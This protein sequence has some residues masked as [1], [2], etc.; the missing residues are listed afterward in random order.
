MK[1]TQAITKILA[2]KYHKSTLSQIKITMAKT[3]EVP[4]QLTAMFET[5][6]NTTKN[7][8]IK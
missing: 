2:N 6:K 1:Q 8:T 4:Q 7:P 5:K 3:N